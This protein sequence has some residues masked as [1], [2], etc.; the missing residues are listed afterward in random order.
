MM[1]EGYLCY[2]HWSIKRLP[3]PFDRTE[4][5]VGEV[6]RT[7]CWEEEGSKAVPL[8]VPIRLITICNV[9]WYQGIHAGRTLYT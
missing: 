4:N 6:N 1:E 8:S 5:Q 3:W 9:I 2:F 7:E